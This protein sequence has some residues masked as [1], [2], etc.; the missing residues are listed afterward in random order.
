M[1]K[2]AFEQPVQE[3]DKTINVWEEIDK[4]LPATLESTSFKIPYKQI[5]VRQLITRTE[6]AREIGKEAPAQSFVGRK[7]SRKSFQ[8]PLS[9]EEYVAIKSNRG[10]S[11]Q[12]L[13]SYPGESGVNKPEVSLDNLPKPEDIVLSQKS[14]YRELMDDKRSVKLSRIVKGT[15][16]KGQEDQSF[17]YLDNSSDKPKTGYVLREQA[18]NNPDFDFLTRGFV[19]KRNEDSSDA[20]LFCKAQSSKLNNDT[21]FF[22]VEYLDGKPVNIIARSIPLKELPIFEEV[23]REKPEVFL[24]SL[25]YQ[26]C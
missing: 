23:L 1:S 2:T 6:F 12:L 3:Q 22:A 20:I 14:K 15:N 26:Q 10:N 18:W 16:I 8:H 7:I 4:E 25:I 11:P 24:G 5:S 13:F 9:R 21:L 17:Y 19:L